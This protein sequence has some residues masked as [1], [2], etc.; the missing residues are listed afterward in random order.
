MLKFIENDELV[1]AAETTIY[2]VADI[3]K[4][5]NDFCKKTNSFHDDPEQKHPTN[6]WDK[7]GNNHHSK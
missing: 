4:K 6:N 3:T 2:E 5:I 7:A 1:N